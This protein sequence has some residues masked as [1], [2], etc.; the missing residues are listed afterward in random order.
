MVC[1]HHD[2]NSKPLVMNL[3][4]LCPDGHKAP[5]L[6][7]SS[8]YCYLT[9]A[10]LKWMCIRTMHSVNAAHFKTQKQQIVS[11]SAQS[12][13]SDGRQPVKQQC[14]VHSIWSRKR[15]L[16]LQD[17]RGMN[18]QT[19]LTCLSGHSVWIIDR[20]RLFVCTYPRLLSWFTERW[21]TGLSKCWF[22]C[23]CKTA[24]A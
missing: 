10:K 7:K 18:P 9:S 12:S 15:L 23:F 4:P 11:Q 21:M 17:D 24:V 8:Q 14:A 20:S 2:Q 1:S 13:S 6:R 16:S 22:N 19:C 5:S 3:I